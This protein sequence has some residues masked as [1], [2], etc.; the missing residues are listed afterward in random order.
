MGGVVM[1]F[2]SLNLEKA[3]MLRRKPMSV[4]SGK[5]FTYNFTS[6]QIDN[7][8][9]HLETVYTG[10]K[11]VRVDFVVKLL[12]LNELYGD[13]LFEKANVQCKNPEN[14]S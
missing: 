2:T 11:Y 7:A 9:K 14:L 13:D 4:P 6:T 5:E 1:N 12:V 3:E 8:K 10:N